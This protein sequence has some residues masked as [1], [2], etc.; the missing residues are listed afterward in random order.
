M[1]GPISEMN[2]LY[3]YVA[4]SSPSELIDCSN[5]T[6]DFE[7][8]KFLNIGFDPK[9]KF[10]IVLRI[11]TPARYVNISPDFLKRIY[12]FMGNILSHIL[13][14]TVKYKKFTFLER[15]SVLITRMVCGEHELVVESKETS[16]CRI[17][18]NR[19]DLMTIQNLEWIIFETVSRKINILAIN[20]MTKSRNSLKT[21]DAPA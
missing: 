19:R 13:D 3:K 2:R 20:W 16:E 5:F 6:I 10:N 4:P 21:V 12:S 17:L 8:R 1:A 18:L 11:I 9:D 15:E 7:N 14:P